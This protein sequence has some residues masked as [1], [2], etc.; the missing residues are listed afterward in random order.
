MGLLTEDVM[1]WAAC[2]SLLAMLA[3]GYGMIGRSRIGD[4]SGRL[5]LGVFFGGI[6]V[7]MMKLEVEPAPGIIVDLRAVPL[8]LAGAFLGRR[9]VA[10]CAAMAAMARYDV[11]GIGT[12]SGVVSVFLYGGAGLA[13]AR[14]IRGR[15]RTERD[16]LLLGAFSP[17]GLAAVLVLPTDLAIWFMTQ[18]APF[19]TAITVPTTIAIAWVL[20]REVRALDAEARMRFAVP[21]DPATG[22]LTMDGLRREL[23]LRDAADIHARETGTGLAVLRPGSIRWI[24]RVH[25][26]HALDVLRGAI[27]HRLARVVGQGALLALCERGEIAVVIPG[28]DRLSALSVLRKAI[29]DAVAEPVALPDGTLLRV[30]VLPGMSWGEGGGAGLDHLLEE[31]RADMAQPRGRLRERHMETLSLADQLFERA[32]RTRV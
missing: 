8:V 19:L 18:V 32:A 31:A 3:S 21:V 25:G 1:Q 30:D 16:L 27:R 13:W 15:P 9:G 26:D 17:L 23:M 22:L 6:A 2:L 14:L 28:S 7:L 12:V 20:Q 24:R 11:G 29:H 10:A 4:A 5:L